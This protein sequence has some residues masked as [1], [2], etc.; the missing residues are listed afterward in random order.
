MLRNKHSNTAGGV[1]E[2]L[3]PLHLE[4]DPVGVEILR[5]M[6]DQLTEMGFIY[7]N[8]GGNDIV[9]RALPTFMGRMEAHQ[10]LIDLASGNE[11]HDQCTP[12]D[13]QFLPDN[14]PL[15]DR[16]MALTACRGAVKA[17]DQ[18]SLNEMEN[19]LDDLFDCE[20]PLHCAHGRPTMIR[21]PMTALERWF[22][23]VL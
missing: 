4:M 18:L 15:K 12:P 23:R 19:L 17:H 1:Q 22:K 7:E 6:E 21:L 3:E 20:I 8:F 5:D 16:I 14:I 10:V 2:L 11:F 13:P 9:I